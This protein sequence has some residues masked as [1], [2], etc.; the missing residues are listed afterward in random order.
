MSDSSSDSEAEL[1]IADDVVV[2]K[3]KMA[4]SMN[5]KVMKALITKC[6]AGA[7]SLDL[8]KFGDEQIVKEASTVYKKEKEMLKGVAFPTCISVN[9]CVCHYSPLESEKDVV[10]LA[11]GD[12]VKIDLAVHIAGFIAS[13]AHTLVVGATKDNPVTGRKADALKAAFTTAE[14]ALRLVKVGNKTT[15]VTEAYDKISSDFKC[16]PVEGM[17]SHQLQEHRID[18][19]K[20]IISNP[21]E[22]Q[23]QDHEENE[24]EV[25]EVY[26]LDCFVS[27]GDGHA[28]ETGTRTTIYKRNEQVIYQLKMKASRAVFSEIEKKHD[29]MCFTLRSLEDEKRSKMG[30][31]ECVKHELCTQFPVVYEKEGENVAQFKFTVLLMPKGPL[32][33]T[34]NFYDPALCNSEHDVENSEMKALLQTSTSR[35]AAKKKK[36]KALSKAA[37]ENNN[38]TTMMDVAAAQ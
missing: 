30:I 10:I 23:K 11:D 3:Y 22:K 36:K 14:A 9:N 20:T 18:G 34:S 38:G 26:A 27:T 25:H 37:A 16:S 1:T 15:Q 13:A 21:S 33:I 4:G 6:I 28:R 7:N 2:T 32:R 35:R 12:M 17:L 5:D 29:T 31:V 19:E 8:C 24:F